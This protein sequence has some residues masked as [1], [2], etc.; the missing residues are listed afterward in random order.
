ML[1]LLNPYYY[2]IKL[3]N[4]LYDMGFIKAC[5]PSVP[6]ISVGN[7]S[8]GG[9]GKSS[10]VRYLAQMLSEDLHPCILSRG[11]RRKSSG[12][13]LVSE[14]G[15]LLASWQESGDEPYMLAKVLPCVSLVVDEDRCR[16]AD[17]AL[18]RLK[19]DLFL[20][21]DGF[22]HRKIQRDLNI[23]LLKKRD[24]SD[25]LL[26]YGRLREPLSSIQRADLVV[27]AYAEL[28]DF[29]WQHPQKP[30]LKMRRENWRV[31]RSSDQKLLEN[32]QNIS[33]IAFAGLGDNWQFFKT[34][35]R[36]GIRLKKKLSLP[37]HYHYEGFELQEDEFYI[38]TLK[39]AVKLPPSHNLYYLDFDVKVDGLSGVLEKLIFS[40]LKG[41]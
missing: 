27:L 37:D 13:L 25:K 1:D 18:R 6:V 7:L 34:L 21:D 16:G 10:L 14:R 35:K 15:S 5:R 30:T 22:Q 4:W 40:K 32:P 23:L 8:L 26:P 17:F 19:P 2:G 24:L 3:R 12:T 41:R 11:Y 29:D 28:E 9:S 38:T 39:D 31:V 33:F 20:L 36:L